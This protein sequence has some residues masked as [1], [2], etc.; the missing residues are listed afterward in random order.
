LYWLSKS[1]CEHVIS[2]PKSQSVHACVRA[3]TRVDELV[4]ACA[5][6]ARARKGDEPGGVR[7]R[8]TCDAFETRRVYVGYT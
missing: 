8:G 5:R 6:D 2:I 4:G 1:R 7:T 3:N